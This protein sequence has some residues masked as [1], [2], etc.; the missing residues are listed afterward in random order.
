M[1]TGHVAPREITESPDAAIATWSHP[2][3][4]SAPGIAARAKQPTVLTRQSEYSAPPQRKRRSHATK[5]TKPV[6][7]CGQKRHKRH[8]QWRRTCARHEPLE[9]QRG[10][11]ERYL[12]LAAVAGANMH[13][14]STGAGNSVRRGRGRSSPRE[15]G[16]RVLDEVV[17]RAGV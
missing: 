12:P 15:A 14:V 10:C 6:S 1:A 16:A 13:G 11:P 7:S 17:E 9:H 4:L 5:S 2:T 8:W 3:R